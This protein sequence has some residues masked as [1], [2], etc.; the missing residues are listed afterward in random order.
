L[1]EIFQQKLLNKMK[2]VLEWMSIT[3][4]IRFLRLGL[5][6]PS[7]AFV[8]ILST[9]C[10]SATDIFV[11]ADPQYRAADKYYPSPS[12]QESYY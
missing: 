3:R 6:G 9:I 12:R 5:L 4:S 11:E 2:S 7:F 1:K 8:L 10:V